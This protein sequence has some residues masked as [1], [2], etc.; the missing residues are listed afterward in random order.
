MK[1]P[2]TIAY[3]AAQDILALPKEYN[4]TGVN[5][6]F[7]NSVYWDEA[8]HQLYR[9]VDEFNALVHVLGPLTTALGL[10]ISTTAKPDAQ[11]PW[12]CIWKGML[13]VRRTLDLPA[14]MLPL[15]QV[16]PT[17]VLLASPLHLLDSSF[18]LVAE[19]TPTSSSWSSSK[20]PNMTI[21]LPAYRSWLPDIPG[22]STVPLGDVVIGQ[23]CCKDVHGAVGEDNSG[24]YCI[25]E[26]VWEPLVA[27]E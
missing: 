26:G 3:D 2:P 18:S 25:T 5:V 4:I 13:T 22:E 17:S 14:V 16:N 19:S 23:A 10:Q 12:R 24:V 27:D 8:D 6:H 11:V 21:T 1:K 7:R 9:S 20:S 15:V